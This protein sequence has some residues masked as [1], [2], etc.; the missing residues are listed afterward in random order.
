MLT[1][2]YIAMYNKHKPDW[3]VLW[4][5]F[6]FSLQINSTIAGI[7]YSNFMDREMGILCPSLIDFYIQVALRNGFREA[8]I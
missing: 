5:L 2:D 6:R 4:Q 7:L 3:K 1:R 8:Q